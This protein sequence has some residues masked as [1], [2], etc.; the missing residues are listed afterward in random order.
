MKQFFFK[1]NIINDFK[2]NTTINN[3]FSIN[4]LKISFL[5]N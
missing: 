5:Y 1:L 3:I 4:F 2:K